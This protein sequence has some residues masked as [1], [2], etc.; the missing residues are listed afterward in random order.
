MPSRPSGD[1]PPVRY[2]LEH[3]DQRLSYA[4]LEAEANRIAHV[5]RDRGVRRG[6]RVVTRG[7]ERLQPGQEVVL[8]KGS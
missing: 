2:I 4:S 6:D 7:A 5:L 3:G 1:E 8:A